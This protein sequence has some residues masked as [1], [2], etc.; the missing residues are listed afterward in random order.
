MA[1]SKAIRSERFAKRQ[2]QDGVALVV[3]FI[4]GFDYRYQR[5]GCEAIDFFGECF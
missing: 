5:L 4:S 2:A 3:V 1:S